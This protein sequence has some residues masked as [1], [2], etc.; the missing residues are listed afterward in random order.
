MRRMSA[1]VRIRFNTAML[2]GIVNILDCVA[3]RADKLRIAR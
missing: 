2:A 3:R 1:Q